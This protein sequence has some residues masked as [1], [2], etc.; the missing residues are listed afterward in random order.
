MLLI[1]YI[2]DL[3]KN[4]KINYI[5][6]TLPEQEYDPNYKPPGYRL[7]RNEDNP[8][9]EIIEAEEPQE[10]RRRGG[11]LGRAARAVATGLAVAA[12]VV[13]V[14]KLAPIVVSGAVAIKAGTTAIKAGN[15]ARGL[16]T[17]ARG[18]LQIGLS[19]LVP[20]ITSYTALNAVNEINQ[21]DTA[22]EVI[23]YLGR[24]VSQIARQRYMGDYQTSL[25]H[26]FTMSL[27]IISPTPLIFT[28]GSNLVYNIDNWEEGVEQN[29][30]WHAVETGLFALS[31][32]IGTYSG[33]RDVQRLN[34]WFNSKIFLRRPATR[35]GTLNIGAGSNPTR[36]AYNID[37]TP[38]VPGVRVGNA[39]D[40][41][42]IRTGS[43][44]LI[45]IDNP[46][47][48]D[49]LNSEI[50]R[51]LQP[52]GIIEV[53]GSNSNPFFNKI[54]KKLAG[55]GL[56]LVRTETVTNIGQFTDSDG[57]VIPVD[58]TEEFIRRIL[59]LIQ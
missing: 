33:I 16:L 34:R 35:N 49:P 48:F 36:G 22:E 43:Q 3:Y 25:G 17:G 24:Y 52:G 4:Y 2:I 58:R 20:A 39:T 50:L 55:T 28:S 6:E 7:T 38:R 11:W 44:S 46:Y 12:A 32:G 30:W 14:V 45:I 18:V 9:T 1:R 23:D 40:L 56:R 59:E 54:L 53:T 47:K 57:I 31:T 13:V 27:S 8:Q 10:E 21:L 41:S 15:V 42:N 51:V 26:L 37:L 19:G 29:G 5:L